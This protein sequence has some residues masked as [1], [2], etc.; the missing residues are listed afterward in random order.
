VDYF[1]FDSG[2]RPT[3]YAIALDATKA[4]NRVSHFRLFRPTALLRTGMRRCIVYLL[5][6]CMLPC[7][8][9]RTIRVILK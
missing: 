6:D 4:Y 7:V 5:E 1:F 3:V 8:G 2:S 9:F